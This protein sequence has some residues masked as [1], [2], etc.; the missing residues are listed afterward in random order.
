MAVSPVTR[1]AVRLML[2]LPR[3]SRPVGQSKK[4]TSEPGDARPSP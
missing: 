2:W 1:N 4:V 3:R